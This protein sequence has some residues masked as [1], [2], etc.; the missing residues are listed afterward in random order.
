MVLYRI[1]EGCKEG[2]LADGDV[3]HIQKGNEAAVD[4]R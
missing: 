2:T 4:M 1:K 3:H